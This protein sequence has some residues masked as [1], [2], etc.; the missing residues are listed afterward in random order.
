MFSLAT[1]G[2][3]PPVRLGERDWDAELQTLALPIAGSLAAIVTPQHELHGITYDGRTDLLIASGLPPS[4]V[5][6]T[7][8]SPGWTH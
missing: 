5:S 4:G 1:T 8:T 6:Q 2:T 7:R 3:A